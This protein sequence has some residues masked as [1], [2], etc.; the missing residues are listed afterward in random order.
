MKRPKA[1]IPIVDPNGGRNVDGLSKQGSTEDDDH[2]G[3]SGIGGGGKN[4]SVV[5]VSDGK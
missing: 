5:T 3:S 1:A 4:A 2:S